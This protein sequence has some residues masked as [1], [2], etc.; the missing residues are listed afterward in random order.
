MIN[1]E[2]LATIKSEELI[3]ELIG[4]L[5][6][7]TKSYSALQNQFALKKRLLK[8]TYNIIRVRT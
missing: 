8:Q 2:A 7:G 3:S 5:S 1:L 6:A 4:L